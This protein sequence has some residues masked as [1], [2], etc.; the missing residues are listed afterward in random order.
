MAEGQIL[1][2]RMRVSP[3]HMVYVGVDPGASGGL[4]VISGE[5]TECLPMPNTPRE[6]WDWF[7]QLRTDFQGSTLIGAI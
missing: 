2:G 6:V 7:S 3:L 4:A 1:S 5:M